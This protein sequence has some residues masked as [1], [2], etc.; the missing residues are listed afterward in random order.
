MMLVILSCPPL[1]LRQASTANLNPFPVYL[2]QPPSYASSKRSASGYLWRASTYSEA[3][4]VEQASRHFG[5]RVVPHVIRIKGSLYRLR[6][7]LFFCVAS[8]EDRGSPPRLLPH[9]PMYVLA[10]CGGFPALLMYRRKIL[11]FPL[12]TASHVGFTT[13][14]CARLLIVLHIRCVAWLEPP[15]PRSHPSWKRR[16]AP[17]C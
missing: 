13:G 2:G 15:H 5:S 12:C 8:V 9:S 3:L 7:S 4:T 6:L 1:R 16:P 14:R 10:D 17:T 11:C